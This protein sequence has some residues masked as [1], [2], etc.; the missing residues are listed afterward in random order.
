MIDDPIN[1]FRL[2][3]EKEHLKK[4]GRGVLEFFWKTCFSVDPILINAEAAEL[5]F[6]FVIL[7]ALVAIMVN[8]FESIGYGFFL[9]GLGVWM[10]SWPVVA[11]MCQ[12]A[13]SRSVI[14]RGA[15]LS[16]LLWVSSAL[17]DNGL[18]AAIRICLL[19]CYV[20]LILRDLSAHSLA[21]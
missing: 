3:E 6:R 18:L 8:A 21:R 17:P 11:S 20:N 10:S 1:S 16:S 13:R 12:S 2:E 19:L 7:S 9:L 4:E 5:L 15:G 14:A